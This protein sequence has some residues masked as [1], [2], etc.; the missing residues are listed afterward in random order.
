[1]VSISCRPISPRPQPRLSTQAEA[2]G[3]FLYLRAIKDERVLEAWVSEEAGGP[4]TLLDTWPVAA[5]SGALGPKRKEGDRQVPEGLYVIDRFNPRSQYHLS[6]GLNYPNASDTILGDPR[7]PGSD[8]FIHGSNKSIGCLAMT[9]P[10]IE[11]IYALAE[12]AHSAGQRAIRVDIFPFRMSEARVEE[13]GREHPEH[14]KFWRG[15]APFFV[16]SDEIASPVPFEVREDG[17]YVRN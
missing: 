3:S 15:L 10:V 14:A 1:M 7:S 2:S 5:M 8:I 12:R 11:Q 4:F 16:N 17:S 13:M 6:L 9:D